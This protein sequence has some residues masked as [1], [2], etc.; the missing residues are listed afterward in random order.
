MD[1]GKIFCVSKALQNFCG[2][3]C[4][5]WIRNFACVAFTVSLERNRSTGKQRREISNYCNESR[6]ESPYLIY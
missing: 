2:N 4:I 3:T 1:T 6:E 5:V